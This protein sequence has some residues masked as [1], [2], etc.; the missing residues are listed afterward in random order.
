[1]LGP[2]FGKDMKAIA[3]VVNQFGAKDID[4]IEQNGHL[5]VEVNGKMIILELGD[6][7]ITS[8]DIEGWLVAN[9]GALTVALDVTISEDLRNEGV[10]RELVNRIQ[11]LR[12]DSG[13][14]VTD[15]IEVKLQKDRNIE[16][17]VI[18]NIDYIK[19]ETLT[20]NLE[21]IDRV[22][23]GIE[24]VFDNVNTKLFIKKH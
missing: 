14:E 16:N 2:R 4:K 22:E 6:V 23:S 15:R 5:E 11:N 18:N 10:A 20:E 17:A 9:E 1:M 7:E 12:K 8:Q 21:F 13:Y 3:S 24:I 19:T